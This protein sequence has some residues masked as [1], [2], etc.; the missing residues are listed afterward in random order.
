MKKILNNKLFDE[1]YKH[2]IRPLL[3]EQILMTIIS[4]INVFLFS[5]FNDEIV[6]AIGISDQI[7]AIASMFLGIVSLGS[8]ILFIQYADEKF[9]KQI[10]A[11][12]KQSI[13][14]KVVLSLIIVLVF[15]VFVVSL[16]DMMNTPEELKSMSINYLKISSYGL[17]FM[18]VTNLLVALNR[19]F[20]KVKSAM[21]VTVINTI[22]LIFGNF[23]CIVF[24]IMKDQVIIQVAISMVLTRFIGLLI[25]CY[26]TYIN[27][28]GV[29]KN[30]KEEKDTKNYIPT[31]LSLGLPS[32]MES[33]SYNISQTIITALIASIGTQVVS[34]KIY[35]QTLTSFIFSIG[36]AAAMSGQIIIGRKIRDKE[37]SSIVDFILLN[38]KT[39]VTIAFAINTVLAI[40]SPL[41]LKLFTKDQQIIAIS[42]ILM[43]MQM[44]N[45]PL[46]VS[47]EILVM[48]LNVLKDV[49][50]PVFSSLIVTY[51]MKIP[52]AYLFTKV[53]SLGIFGIWTI[54]ILD[55]FI[56]A[57]LFVRRLKNKEWRFDEIHE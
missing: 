21:N 36:A 54:F 49:N 5:L 14:L 13:L 47:N 34:S 9:S 30:S 16:V 53:F 17:V 18:G 24:P 20:G 32:A 50:Y 3:L 25:A 7:V 45:D 31:I 38:T 57:M 1:N 37:Y 42:I 22:L 28:R 43:I 56:R 6:A 15:N 46:R 51:L 12:L 29:F 27:L 11:I 55:E 8:T 23:L 10:M 40:G 19:S 2:L 4:N 41:L 33:I 26:V 52:L 35:V 44:L 48:S 39:F